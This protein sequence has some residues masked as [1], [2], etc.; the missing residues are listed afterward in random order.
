M[1]RQRHNSEPDKDAHSK[2]Y[3]EVALKIVKEDN[4][5]SELVKEE[6]DIIVN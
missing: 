5:D 4:M 1:R 6:K 2:R 3:H